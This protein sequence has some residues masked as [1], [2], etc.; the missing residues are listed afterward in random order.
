MAPQR[1]TAGIAAA[2]ATASAIAPAIIP[3]A[4]SRAVASPFTRAITSRLASATAG[5]APKMPAN[6][7]GC[8]IS[9]RTANKATNKP[10]SIALRQMSSRVGTGRFPSAPQGGPGAKT[11]PPGLRFR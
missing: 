9:P 6:R 7:L 11:A 4:A 3:V 8:N 2:H 10:P 1:R 5:D